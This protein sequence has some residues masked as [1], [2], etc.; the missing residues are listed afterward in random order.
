MS[1]HLR[2]L[3]VALLLILSGAPA[4]AQGV[5]Q[6]GDPNAAAAAKPTDP[7]VRRALTI[8]D[9]KRWRAVADEQLSPDGKWVAY[10]LRYT[11]VPAADVKPEVHILNLDTNRDTVVH[12]AT[13]PRFSADSRWITYQ[14]ELPPPGRDSARRGTP[15][16]SAQPGAD[17]SAARNRA[18]TPPP[19]RRRTELRELATGKTRSW[20]DI[21]TAEFSPTASHLLMRRRPAPAAGGARG[22]AGAAPSP[23]PGGFGGAGGF[24]A[25]AAAGMRGRDALLHD[26]STGRT[27]FL[28]SV[29]EAEFN[30]MGTLLAYSVESTVKDGNGLFVADLA[31]ARLHV[32]DNDAMTYNRLAWNDAGTAVATLKAKE[33]P[34]MRERDNVLVAYPDVRAVFGVSADAA[35]A[36]QVTLDTAASGFPKGYVVSDRAALA[37][38][39]DNRRV[40]FGIIPR[41]P[42]PDTARSRSRD[43]VANVDVWSTQDERVQSVQMIRANA[44][45]N[46]TFRQALDVTAGKLI[47]LSDST[48]RDLE[49]APDGRWAV[50]RDARAYVADFGPQRA[51][52][53][54]VNTATGERTLMFREQRAGNHVYGISSDGRHFL[55]WHDEKFHDYNL[56]A[57]ST[58]VLGGTS[59]P[60]FANAEWE[61]PSP[62]PSYGVAG[63]SADARG[64]VVHGKHDLWLLPYD[65]G[66]ARN[67]TR[68]EGDRNEIRF[69]VAR[70]MPVDPMAPRA[71]R[72]REIID[73]SKPVTLSAFGSTTKKNGFYELAGNNLRQTAFQDAL[74]STPERALKANRYLFRRQTFQEYPDLRVSGAAFAE[75]RKVSDANPQQAEFLWGRRMLFE[76]TNRDGKTIQGMVAL[77]DDYV[78]GEKRPMIVSFYERQTDRVHGHTP[79]SF[80]SGMGSVPIEAVSRGY[81]A[82]IPDVHFRTGSSHSDMLESVELA[83]KKVIEMGYADAAKVGVHGH[84]YGGE[85]AAFIATQSKM[86]AAVGMGAGVTDLTSDFA[87]NWGWAYQVNSGS[88]NT[89]Y[90][91]YL[92]GQGRWGK[93][94]WEDPELY[95]RE[96]ALP[97]APQVSMPVLIMHGT[98]D[99]TVSFS[100]GLNFY[101]AL[102]FNKKTAY[103]LAYPGEGHG[104]RGVANRRD[105]TIRYMQFFD[106]YLQGAPAPKWM[107]DGV[108]FLVKETI[109]EPR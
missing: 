23:A 86:F 78:E 102:R 29:G 24:G 43:S 65:G 42:A 79:P 91:Y 93:S 32:I 59:A 64:A 40:F 35:A 18:Q 49:I 26:L 105:L 9:Y 95:R 96:S 19:A 90:E 83:T 97:H 80:L 55:Y 68:G 13:S 12:Y 69:R 2:A 76:F 61:Y 60:S 104:L 1:S 34:K 45:R 27:L 109:K 37:W 103:L 10:V 7:K 39:D 101:N 92:N 75:S 28:G 57:G 16:D 15:R 106:H 85:G 21:Q 87:Q 50:G 71:A 94:P 20:Q 4:L 88:G 82:M 63:Y 8:D 31:T 44:E 14:I 66:S 73:L 84:S 81:I 70:T 62:R 38:S 56:D 17:T 48:M 72:D 36:R 46:F 22:G 41:T 99:P 52:F 107:T 25:S 77:P 51:D 30:R 108:P 53:Y 3:S 58:R 98:A 11:N 6:T 33:V 100:E 67:L 89:A 74:F 54:R 5:V 47:A